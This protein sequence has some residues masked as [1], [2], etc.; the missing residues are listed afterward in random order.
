MLGMR[1]FR[2]CFLLV[3]LA[4]AVVLGVPAADAQEAKTSTVQGHARE[5]RTRFVV[6]ADVLVTP[7]GDG[8][9]FFLT[10]TGAEGEFRVGGLADGE[11]DVAIARAGYVPVTKESVAVKFPFRAVVEVTME[12]GVPGVAA[13]VASS[14]D[15]DAGG[16]VSAR[17]LVRDRE[18]APLD[19]V[20][21]RMLREDDV[22]DPIVTRTPA[23]GSV[24]LVDLPAGEWRLEVIGIG[25]LPVRQRLSLTQDAEIRV[26]L[27]RQ[28]SNY[29]PAPIDLMPQ[30]VPIAPEG[31]ER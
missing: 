2:A 9:R 5:S 25:Y 3:M 26:T 18:G 24:A 21:V 27:V 28:P 14:A 17:L 29:V 1:S 13:E 6:G 20:R 10:S 22:T 23:D 15:V 30:E 16:R 12:P 7:D 19:E 11:Y 31:F 4:V 8:S